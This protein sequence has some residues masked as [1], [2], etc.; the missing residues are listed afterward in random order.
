MTHF[1]YSMMSVIRVSH[2]RDG[3]FHVGKIKKVDFIAC[4]YPLHQPSRHR[5]PPRVYTILIRTQNALTPPLQPPPYYIPRFK[6]NHAQNPSLKSGGFPCSD[7]PQEEKC[8]PF[9][10]SSAVFWPSSWSELCS[11]CCLSQQRGGTGPPLR[12]HSLRLSQP[13]A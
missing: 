11:L 5:L 6:N 10:S 7:Y 12:Q 3:S 4:D 9:K 8:L 1:M 13:S 2:E